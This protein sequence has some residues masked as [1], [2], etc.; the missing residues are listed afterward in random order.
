M[1]IQQFDLQVQLKV[2]KTRKTVWISVRHA[3]KV[4]VMDCVGMSANAGH[5]CAETAV[6]IKAATTTA[7]AVKKIPTPFPVYFLGTSR[8][9]ATSVEHEKLGV[10]LCCLW[11]VSFVCG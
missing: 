2:T 1:V 8:V 5:G 10:D 3:K 6:S 11:C 7:T 4:A 9:K